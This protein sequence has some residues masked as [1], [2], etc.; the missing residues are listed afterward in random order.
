M[1]LPIWAKYV[2]RVFADKTLGYDENEQFQL[3]DGFDPCKDNGD[4]NL[5]P[6]S[7]NGLDDWFE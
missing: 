1:A 2:V 4:I 6:A 5:E 3:P 7:E